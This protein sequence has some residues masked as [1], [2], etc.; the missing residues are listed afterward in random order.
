MFYANKNSNII[1]LNLVVELSHSSKR[2]KENIVP[3][4]DHQNELLSDFSFFKVKNCI[5]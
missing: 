1:E 2:K 4:L 3:S 5:R